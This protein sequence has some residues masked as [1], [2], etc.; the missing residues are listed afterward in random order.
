MIA[1]KEEERSSRFSDAS[2]DGDAGVVP[3]R[4]ARKFHFNGRIMQGASR[5]RGTNIIRRSF[6][7]WISL[8]RTIMGTMVAGIIVIMFVH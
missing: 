3:T 8:P 1:V 4:N 5:W 6:S 7:E 2:E